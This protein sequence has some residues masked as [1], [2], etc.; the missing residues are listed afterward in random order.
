LLWG[1]IV[2][3]RGVL[4][5]HDG[6]KGTHQGVGVET[7]GGLEVRESRPSIRIEQ[8]VLGLEISVAHS[9]RVQFVQSPDDLLD[10]V[11]NALR[12]SL[13]L[14]RLL[15]WP[16]RAELHDHKERVKR[17]ILGSNY[18]L[19]EFRGASHVASL[20]FQTIGGIWRDRSL[21]GGHSIEVNVLGPED[22]RLTPLA[23]QFEQVP[24]AQLRASL[25][26]DLLLLVGKWAILLCFGW[27]HRM[28]V[29][30]RGDGP[31]SRIGREFGGSQRQARKDD[32]LASGV[33]GPVFSLVLP[34][35]QVSWQ[36]TCLPLGVTRD[37]FFHALA[38]DLAVMVVA[39]RW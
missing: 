2:G 35:L 15:Q 3:R 32:F 26:G 22:P 34:Q 33:R 1:E 36:R 19:A 39:A 17:Q 14:E 6:V 25:D 30:V 27:R 8:D 31:G 37:E 10:Q 16:T 29:R 12:R 13:N 38:S 21:E 5:S 7:R 28:I 23:N 24:R 18:A 11:A 4:D 20:L 9:T